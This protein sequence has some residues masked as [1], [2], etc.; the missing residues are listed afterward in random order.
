MGSAF[1]SSQSGIFLNN[2]EAEV[3][4]M[5][6]KPEERAVLGIWSSPHESSQSIVSEMDSFHK[7]NE[8]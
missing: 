3:N 7:Y 5:G 2:P 8:M 6:V 1:W 4:T